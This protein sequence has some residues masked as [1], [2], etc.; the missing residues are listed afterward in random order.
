LQTTKIEDW[1]RA[2]PG[3]ASPLKVFEGVLGGLFSKSFPLKTHPLKTHP[4]K[5]YPLN[6]HLFFF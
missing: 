1:V 6:P 2:L 4:L 5:T 3:G